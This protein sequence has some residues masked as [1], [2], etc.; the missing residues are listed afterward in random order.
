MSISPPVDIYNAQTKDTQYKSMVKRLDWGVI[1]AQ[2]TIRV[3]C[4]KA[5]VMGIFDRLSFCGPNLQ[6]SPL[7]SDLLYMYDP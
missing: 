3:F 7:Y 2:N 1:T 4:D 5:I 6:I